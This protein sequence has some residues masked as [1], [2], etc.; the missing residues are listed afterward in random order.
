MNV[1]TQFCGLTIL[2]VI[3]YF[4]IYH[5]KVKLKTERAFFRF[6]VVALLC[7]SLDITSVFAIARIDT[8]NKT[9][10]DIICKAYVASVVA[11]IHAALM[12]VCVDIYTE[13][14]SYVRLR[15]VFDTLLLIGYISVFA[16]PI[17]YH[18][19][20]DTG[21]VYTYGFSV[22]TGYAFGFVFLVFLIF[23]LFFKSK[24]MNSR[25]KNA[26]AVWLSIWTV[27]VI[28]QFLNNEILLLS[29]AGSLGLV[30]VYLF[31][32][33]PETNL[34]KETGAF[35]QN[36]M[37]QYIPQLYNEGKKFSSL[38]LIVDGGMGKSAVE[39]CK[40]LLTIKGIK[41]F[42]YSSNNIMIIFEDGRDVLEVKR[43]ITE[44]FEQGF[45]KDHNI[46]LKPYWYYMQDPDVV[47]YSKD[48]F[49]LVRYAHHVPVD[50]TST[51]IVAIDDIM[52]QDM[53]KSKHITKLLES[54]IENDEVEV[55][56][57]PI[58][59]VSDGKFLTAEA[60][61]RIRDEFGEIIKPGA[62]I[63]IAEKNGM[64]IKLG[65]M[66]FEKVCRFISSPGFEDL[67]LERIEVNLSVTQCSHSSLAADYVLIMNKYNVD[68]R[69]INLEITETAN[70]GAKKVLLK[71]MS[72]LKEQGIEFALDDFGTGH[73]N[74]NYITEMP[75]DIL[76]FD[77]GMTQLYFEN[78]KAKYV[79][80]AAINMARGM[81]LSIV[82]EG[83]ETGEQYKEAE[84]IGIDYIQGYYFAQPMPEQEFCN[85]LKKHA[86]G[87]DSSIDL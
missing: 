87:L 3:L 41:I 28:V 23:N 27:A 81:D 63:D 25:R 2:L 50:W 49:N 51:D 13:R 64:I 29:F 42:K 54:A 70:A 71:N 10:L 22:L 86:I 72:I 24:N 80:D 67:G 56:Y 18:Y 69:R 35:N 85:F 52:A 73:S 43:I 1:N 84:R 47:E 78:D 59:S 31:L 61:V 7:V 33:N 62:F 46:I 58:Y 45:G 75:V 16:L 5:A 82:F 57:Q 4:Y 37:L 20:Q 6:F 66:V 8:I 32:E 68:P 19:E 21:V 39:I 48:Y 11:S 60:L 55:F 74:L 40:F 34:D 36:A 9:L 14:K 17:Q 53:Y 83:V 30:I 44:R 12:Y 26:M 38:E 77:M 65:E 15:V 79:M 76:K